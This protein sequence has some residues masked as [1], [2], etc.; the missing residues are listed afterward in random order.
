MVSK[1]GWCLR[2]RR[3]IVGLVV[4]SGLDGVA[5]ADILSAEFEL[6]ALE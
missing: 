6:T 5:W 4:A 3:R 2:D 1:K